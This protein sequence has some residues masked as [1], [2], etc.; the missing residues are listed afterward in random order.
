MK[1]A[2]ESRRGYN[3]Q[4]NFIGKAERRVVDLQ[5]LRHKMGIVNEGT[6]ESYHQ[7]QISVSSQ[8]SRHLRPIAKASHK[9]L[10]M[11]SIRPLVLGLNLIIPSDGLRIGW[12]WGAIA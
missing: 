9:A 6:L 1:I 8:S 4:R 7:S 5:Q 3:Y 2:N 10:M 12:W 11:L